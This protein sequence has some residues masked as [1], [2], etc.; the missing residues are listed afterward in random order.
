MKP[1]HQT[2]LTSDQPSQWS[3]EDF[4]LDWNVWDAGLDISDQC[5]DWLNDGFDF[6]IGYEPVNDL[7][8]LGGPKERK[9]GREHGNNLSSSRGATRAESSAAVPSISATPVGRGAAT[10][11]FACEVCGETFGKR[12]SLKRHVATVHQAASHSCVQCHKTFKRPDT[13][14]R[15]V[16]EQHGEGTQTEGKRPD[17]VVCVVCGAKVRPSGLSDHQNSKACQNAQVIQVHN[18]SGAKEPSA[19]SSPV[20]R[21]QMGPDND[22]DQ[23]TGNAHLRT[24]SQQ[25]A[26]RRITVVHAPLE[27]EN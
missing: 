2:G 15:H 7:D 10:T 1:N 13:L 20:T 9:Q 17:K 25:L 4:D 16:A 6:S 24:L 5:F 11:T 12:E 19:V 3:A 21:P 23:S 18:L 22:E 26:E 14:K 27:I 8:L